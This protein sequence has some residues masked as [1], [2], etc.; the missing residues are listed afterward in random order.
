L[1][2]CSP[3][4]GVL[5]QGRLAD[6]RLAAENEDAATG[7]ARSVKQL[8]NPGLLVIPPVEHEAIVRL[9]DTIVR[10][11]L[12]L[13]PAPSGSSPREPKDTLAENFAVSG[14]A[15]ATEKAICRPRQSMH[16]S[17]CLS[18]AGAGQAERREIETRVLGLLDQAPE[19]S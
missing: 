13:R 6:P 19:A 15:V 17:M 16:R 12:V 1:H 11:R 2:I 4:A 7:R 8:A 3:H 18:A 14:A 10:V 9:T 5:E